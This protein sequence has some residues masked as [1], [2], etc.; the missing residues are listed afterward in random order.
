MNAADLVPEIRKAAAAL[1]KA[2]SE[3]FGLHLFL[4][5]ELG[6]LLNQAKADPDVGAHGKWEAWFKAQRFGFSIRKAQRCMHFADNKQKLEAK[7]KTSRLSFLAQEHR[8]TICNA[9]AL[10]RKSKPAGPRKA[11]P[12]ASKPK[13]GLEPP[14][15]TPRSSDPEMVLGEL[16]VDEV[17]SIV[18]ETWDWEKQDQ[19]LV[20]QLRTLTPTRVFDLLVRACDDDQLQSLNEQITEHLKSHS[21]AIRKVGAER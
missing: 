1:M 13:A 4:A 11:K 7:A 20:L 15:P 12:K 18:G 2:E 10:L 6:T 14:V 8:L 3:A 17:A 16:D 21:A 19:L 9:D 5:I